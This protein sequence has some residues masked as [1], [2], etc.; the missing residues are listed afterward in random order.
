MRGVLPLAIALPLWVCAAQPAI[1]TAKGTWWMYRGTVTTAG[2]TRPVE[3]KAEVAEVVRRGAVE[4]ARITGCPLALAE[5]S[6]APG[7]CILVK[8][9]PN[10]VYLVD[11]PRNGEVM[12]RVRDTADELVGLLHESELVFDFPLVAG[13]R[14]GETAQITRQCESASCGYTWVAVND[15]ELVWEGLSGQ[16]RIRVKPGIGISYF[17][18]RHHPSRFA[19]EVQLVKQSR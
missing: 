12:R 1:P 8:V 5:E 15:N 18:M 3:F 10:R 19:V 11:A 7:E 9:A 13:K 2:A 6:A 14:I 16:K 4:A 17:S